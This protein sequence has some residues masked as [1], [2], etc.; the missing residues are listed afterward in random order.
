MVRIV[1]DLLHII[2]SDSVTALN[3]LDL[4]AAFDTIDHRLLLMRL[5]ET[6]G[7]SGSALKWFESYLSGRK[8]YVVTNNVRSQEYTLPCGV[9]QGSVLGPILFVLYIGPLSNIFRQHQFLY[10][11]YADDV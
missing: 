8:Q 11:Q 4:S 2:D 3:L 9:P 1:N 5:E 10:H 7:I 6:Y